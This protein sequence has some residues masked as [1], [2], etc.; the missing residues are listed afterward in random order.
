MKNPGRL[1]RASGFLTSF[2]TFE[3]RNLNA[4]KPFIC[5]AVFEAVYFLCL[6]LV[7]TEGRNVNQ[8]FR[9][10]RKLPQRVA[11]GP[12]FVRGGCSGVLPAV[13]IL[14]NKLLGEHFFQEKR[15]EQN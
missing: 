13:G 10:I 9:A 6:L 5:M 1:S 3:A 14:S 15:H 12:R 7:C 11:N 2:P 4:P 8:I